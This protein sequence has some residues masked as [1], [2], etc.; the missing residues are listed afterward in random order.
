MKETFDVVAVDMKKHTVRF[1]DRADD[2]TKDWPDH[3]NWCA[4]FVTITFFG[5]GIYAAID[6]WLR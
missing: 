2:P 4:I 6:L 3:G 1:L 5:F